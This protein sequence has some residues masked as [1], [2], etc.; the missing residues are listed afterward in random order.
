MKK[1]HISYY[2]CTMYAP[3][4]ANS[5]LLLRNPINTQD[6]ITEAYNFLRRVIS[7]AGC[8]SHSEPTILSYIELVDFNGGGKND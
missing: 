8:Y 5:I 7:E 6:G 3:T 4:F 2:Y 1:Y